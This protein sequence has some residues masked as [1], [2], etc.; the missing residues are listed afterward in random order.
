MI[1]SR[2]SERIGAVKP[3]RALQVDSMS[4]ALRNSLWNLFFELYEDQHDRYWERI[5]RHIAKFFRKVPADELP[6]RDS[7][8]REWV[9]DYFFNL[10]WYQAYD[11]LEFLVR[12]HRTMTT[13]SYNDGHSTIQHSVDANRLVSTANV[14]LERELSGF[15]FVQ[16]ALAPI[17]DP[18]EVSEIEYAVETSRRVGLLG[19]QEHIRS[20]V[21][22]LGKKPNPDYRNAIKEAISS[23]ESA[24]KQ[25]TGSE[26]GT[27]D[28][29]LKDLA[30]R[31]DLHGALAA[32]F[33]KLYGY[34]SDEDGIRHAILDQ[35]SVG[36]AEA[37]Y[38]I[39]AC[40]AFVNF[41]IAKAEQAGLLK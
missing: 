7:D 26:S 40:S 30:A 10:P 39:V 15:R 12:N 37:K 29:A 8:L 38:M 33:S 14:I 27:L 24:V 23:V 28:R 20:A 1:M 5:A 9:K 2:F 18:V 13:I 35:P 32:G 11:L 17:T 36:F 19:A 25:I 21:Q 41:L 4:D 3:D 31:V 34:T 16:G 6:W 22:L